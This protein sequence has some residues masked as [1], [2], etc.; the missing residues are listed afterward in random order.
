V[1]AHI[2]LHFALAQIVQMGAP[3]TILL[4]IVSHMLGEKDVSGVSAIHH[5][6][7]Q[8]DSGARYIGAIIHIGNT[9]HRTAVDSHAHPQLRM[10]PQCIANLYRARNRSIRRGCKD[11]CHPVASRQ[12]RQFASS[13]GSAERIGS[14]NNFI[15]GMQIIA[16]LVDQKLGVTDNVDEENMPDL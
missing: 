14:P 4:K 5:S 11:E 9:A 7:R 10:A 1:H 2:V 13:I 8:V 3:L 16:L 12:T 15:E 6:L